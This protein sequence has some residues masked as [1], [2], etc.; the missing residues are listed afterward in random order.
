MLALDAQGVAGDHDP[1]QVGEGSQ[2]RPRLVAFT[3]MQITCLCVREVV[4]SEGGWDRVRMGELVDH[5]DERDLVVGVVERGAAEREG[6]LHRI[7][8][9]IC[10]DRA[11]RILVLRRSGTMSRFPGY[12]DVMVGGAV[13]AGES[14]EEAAARELSEELGVRAP[15]RFLFTFL[16][17]QGVGPVWFGVHEA[18]VAEPLVADPGEIAWRGWLTEAELCEAVDRGLW[19]PGG[20]EALRRY[21]GPG[22]GS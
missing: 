13:N 17:R 4:L 1:G 6:R 16:C 11:G 9:T 19:V 7:A 12:Y 5:V 2:Q 18:V 10:R 3:V 14:Y 21:L 20:Q 8:T 22:A 15:V